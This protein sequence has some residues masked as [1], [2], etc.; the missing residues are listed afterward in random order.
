[1]L[2]FSY[3]INFRLFSM[4]KHTINTHYLN[5]KH[6]LNI[7]FNFKAMCFLVILSARIGKLED[8]VFPDAPIKSI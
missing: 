6:Y 1:M 7:L 3:V 8:G 5:F 2:S 4:N